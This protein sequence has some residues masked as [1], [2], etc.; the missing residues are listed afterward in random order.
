MSA[1]WFGRVAR[2]AAAAFLGM[3]ASTALAQAPE[4]TGD[5]TP[6]FS[7]L[8]EPAP[9]GD[10][11]NKPI[12]PR[13]AGSRDRTVE[14]NE[15]DDG[16][17][18]TSL[19]QRLPAGWETK[20]GVDLGSAAAP[21]VPQ[22]DDYLGR[23]DRGA[24]SGWANMSVPAASIGL[25]KA[26]FGARL[27]PTQD[28]GQLGTTLSRSLPIGSG[29]SLI[30]Q[31]GYSVTQTLGASGAAAGSAPAHVFSGDGGVR[32][33]LPTATAFSADAKLSSTDDKWL[34]SLSAEQKLFDTPVS[35]M[36]TISERADGDTDK[37]I[38]AGFKRTW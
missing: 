12:A 38:K 37:S 28:N 22:L 1:V 24:G 19:S 17:T 15:K 13:P 26:T 29:L 5:A 4:R 33:E 9:G 6:D 23:T 3:A 31:N 14:R 2:A 25:D 7:V 35:I 11:A 8:S 34:R 32:L 10:L 21:L 27:D 30:L 36:G 16:G 20:F 18:T